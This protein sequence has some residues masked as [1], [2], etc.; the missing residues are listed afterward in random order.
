M[1]QINMPRLL[2][3]TTVA[4]VVL[5]GCISQPQT[6]IEPPVAAQVCNCTQLQGW[7]KLERKVSAMSNEKVEKKLTQLGEPKGQRQLFYFGLLN[8]QFDVYEN[9]AQ[10]RDAFRQLAED[11]D[12]A[13][14]QR[15][16][17]A[18]LER[19][20]QTRINWYLQHSHLLEKHETFKTKLRASREENELLEQKIQAITD[21]E[22]SISTRKE[23]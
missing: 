10:A 8:Q 11:D 20:N 23:Q 15:N 4:L 5:S 22:T 2:V 18:I 17:A 19:Y 6:P 16:L 13:K 12:L 14:E 9:W 3:I 1:F 21:L 7:L